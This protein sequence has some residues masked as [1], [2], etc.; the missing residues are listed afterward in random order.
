[1]GRKPKLTP[2]Q[3][4]EAIKTQRRGRRAGPRNCPDLQR[5]P[6]HDF[7]PMTEP[8][9][10]TTGA[11]ATIAG[12][13]KDWPLW[14]FTAIAL[15]LT[16]FS[17]VPGFR[18]LVSPATTHAVAFGAIAAW[19]FAGCRAVAP[20]IRAFHAYRA[21]SAAR[22]QFVVTPVEH[23]C[24]WAMAKQKDGST[25]TQVSGHFLVSNRTDERL[26]FTTARLVRPKIRGEE[27][28]GLLTIRALDSNM[29]GTAGVSGYFVP[30]KATL[31]ASA[32]I[33]FR[34][35]PR[36]K[37][38]VMRAV[39]EFADANGHRERVNLKLD[40]SIAPAE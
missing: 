6:K 7:P 12:R 24:I 14:L 3:K 40:N 34:G 4:R 21:A 39:I 18:Q 35:M 36:Q 1:M 16:V 5:Q 37:S 32:T 13:L 2:H 26:Y 11:L 10:T 20:G 22:V 23:Q 25:V 28:P 29:H 31:P 9:T 19:I 27:L 38:G 15:T 8:V 33:L 17:A 30:P